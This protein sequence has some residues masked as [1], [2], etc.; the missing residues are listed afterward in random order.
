MGDIKW[1]QVLIAFFLGVLGSAAVK[2]AFSKAKGS[3]PGA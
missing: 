1:V 3:V 2:G